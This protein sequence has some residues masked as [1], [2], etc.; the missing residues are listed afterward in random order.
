MSDKEDYDSD[1][2]LNTVELNELQEAIPQTFGGIE[3]SSK[4]APKKEKHVKELA[5]DSDLKPRPQVEVEEM[6]EVEPEPEPEPPKT[7]RGRPK[8]GEEKPKVEVKTK[9]KRAPK[10]VERVIYL[11]PDFEN[12]GYQK[13]KIKPLNNKELKKLENEIEADE[14][15]IKEKTKYLRKVDGKIDNRSKKQRTPAQIEATRKL[16]ENRRKALADKKEQKDS[17]KQKQVKEQKT[18]I[19]ESIEEAVIETVSKP[20]DEV[21][22]DVQERRRKREARMVNRLKVRTDDALSRAKNLFC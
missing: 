22:A 7:K 1:D 21:R 17:D 20:I 11:A 6:P 9:I 10:E 8:K 5:S 4:K 19:K 16:V 18:I 2:S 13:V 3:R 12:G 15:E 14:T